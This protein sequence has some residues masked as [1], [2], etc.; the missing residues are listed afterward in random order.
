MKFPAEFSGINFD[1]TLTIR[2][3]LKYGKV[4]ILCEHLLQIWHHFESTKVISV[5]LLTGTLFHIIN[6]YTY[7][8]LFL[9]KTN[10]RKQKRKQGSE[11][12]NIFDFKNRGLAQEGRHNYQPT[13]QPRIIPLAD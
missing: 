3:M 13:N 7:M 11:L 9:G 5:P 10:E 6:W 1:L 8:N 12:L 2:D 4:S